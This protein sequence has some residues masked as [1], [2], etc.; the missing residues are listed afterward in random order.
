MLPTSTAQGY[1]R[2]WTAR[3]VSVDP[4]ATKTPNFSSYHYANCNPIGNIDVMG[5]SSAPSKPKT[6]G[7]SPG[8]GGGAKGPRAEGPS[9]PGGGGGGGSGGSNEKGGGSNEK[10]GGSKEASPKGGANDGGEQNLFK[11]DISKSSGF[12]GTDLPIIFYV[13]RYSR[14]TAKGDSSSSPY[15]LDDEGVMSS[16]EGAKNNYKLGDYPTY[17]S[18]QFVERSR[19]PFTVREVISVEGERYN[20]HSRQ[21]GHGRDNDQHNFDGILHINEADIAQVFG[22]TFNKIIDKMEGDKKWGLIDVY[23]KMS[24]T[25]DE[26]DFKHKMFSILG[27]KDYKN[28]LI[29]FDGVLYN[30]NEFGNFLWAAFFDYM[31]SLISHDFSGFSHLEGNYLPV[32]NATTLKGAAQYITLKDASRLDEPWEQRAIGDGVSWAQQMFQSRA[33]YNQF[34][35]NVN[36]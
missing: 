22:A 23:E 17:K 30:P 34:I 2:P 6:H 21:T 8:G 33:F 14:K 26:L 3:F 12:E 18:S 28:H 10:G 31:D 13:Q 24:G 7:N 32:G 36:K 11:P 27:K 19:L 20:A 4:L 15:T 9:A 35:Q 25:N 1:Y 16:W 5:L 29:E